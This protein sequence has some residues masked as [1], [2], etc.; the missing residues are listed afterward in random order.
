MRLLGENIHYHGIDIAIHNPA[1]NLIEADFLETPVKFSDRIFDII[2]AQGV[3]EYVGAFQDQKFSE[4]SKLLAKDGKFIVSYWN[5]G[6]RNKDIYWPFSNIRPFKDFRQSLALNF[7]IDKFF[8]VSHNWHHREP[9]RKFIKAAQMHINM[10]IPF[11]SPALAV[12]YFF[13]CSPAPDRDALASPRR[14]LLVRVAVASRG[15]VANCCGGLFT[16]YEPVA[17][18]VNAALLRARSVA[19]AAFTFAE[20]VYGVADTDVTVLPEYGVSPRREAATSRTFEMAM[21]SRDE[22]DRS[23][24]R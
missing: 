21:A 16:C 2:L 17:T 23:G 13:I 14:S 19:S 18:S 11:I 8:P 20:V 24:R 1:P 3:F 5:F 15:W 10:N 7:H 4:I 12:E 22:G 6:H 9:G